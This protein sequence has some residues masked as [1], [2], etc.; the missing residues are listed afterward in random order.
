MNTLIGIGL[1][2]C[3]HLE[4]AEKLRAQTAVLIAEH[5][6]AE[7]YDPHTGEAAGGGAFTWTAAVWL[8]WASPDIGQN[9]GPRNGKA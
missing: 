6:F 8:G 2:D 4:L 7:Y 3:G 1:R 9:T 5:G